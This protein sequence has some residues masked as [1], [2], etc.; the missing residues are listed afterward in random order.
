MVEIFQKRLKISKLE[1][2]E[3]SP[4]QKGTSKLRK[5]HPIDLQTQE[6][7]NAYFG[8]QKAMDTHI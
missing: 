5:W 6:K 3:K 4:L 1:R 8:V 7:L 2:V